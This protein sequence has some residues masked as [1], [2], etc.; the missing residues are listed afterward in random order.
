MAPIKTVR[1]IFAELRKVCQH[2][3]LS[4]PELESFELSEEEQHRQL[5]NTSGK[6][7]F[8]KLLL[9]KLK[10]RGH[11]V[12]LFSQFKI[13][14]DRVEDFLYGEGVN[15][16]R[17]DGDVQQ[18][19]RQKSMDLFNAPNSEYDVFLLTTRA[20]GVG[21]NLATAD[22]VIIYDPD[23]N[24]HQDLQAISRSHRYGQKKRVLVFKLMTKG[25]IEERIMNRG[26]K[27][28]VLDH[29]V[30]QQMG[31]ENEEGDVDDLLLRGAEAVYGDQGGVNALDI[32]YTSK[33]VDELIDKVEADAEAEAKA[34]EEREQAMERGAFEAGP[35]RPTMQ[36]GFAKIWEADQNQLRDAA[37]DDEEEVEN[38]ETNW[39]QIFD[40]M[41]KERQARL[42]REVDDRRTRR[43]RSIQGQYAVDSMD[44]SPASKKK[45]KMI[46]G[47]F[48]ATDGDSSSDADFAINPEDSSDDDDVASI[49]SFPEGLSGL[50]TDDN[51]NVLPR[52]IVT[53]HKLTQKIKRSLKNTQAKT[54]EQSTGTI[55]TVPGPSKHPLTGLAPSKSR[56]RSNETEEQRAARKAAKKQGGTAVPAVAALLEALHGS[57]ANNGVV[58]SLHIPPPLDRQLIDAQNIIS[59][60]FQILSEFND[61][62][63]LKTWAKIG[64]LE[65]SND[66]RLDNYVQ[67]ARLIDDRLAAHGQEQYFSRLQQ[68][69]KVL[70]LIRSR[71]SVIPD[72]PIMP[73]LPDNVGITRPSD[74]GTDNITNGSSSGHGYPP[75]PSLMSAQGHTALVA[76]GSPSADVPTPHLSSSVSSAV[77]APRQPVTTQLLAKTDLGMMP[78]QLANTHSLSQN[79]HKSNSTS[80]NF[81]NSLMDN[82]DDACEFCH[83]NHALP[84]CDRLMSMEDIEQCERAIQ[85]NNEPERQRRDALKALDRQR[86]WN[87]QAGR[88]ASSRQQLIAGPPT[89]GRHTPQ[90]TTPLQ[91]KSVNSSQLHTPLAVNGNGNSHHHGLASGSQGAAIVI[92]DDEDLAPPKGVESHLNGHGSS[93]VASAN[94]SRKTKSLLG[95]AICES[96]ASHSAVQC[97]VVKA[98]PPS[99][100]RALARLGSDHPLYPVVYALWEKQSRT[101]L[102]PSTTQAQAQPQLSDKICPF[103]E[104]QCGRDIKSCVEAHG[105]RKL[106]KAKIR[107]LQL[108]IEKASQVERVITLHDMSAELYQVYQTWPKV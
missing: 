105:G 87:V 13:A 93:P 51:G 41:Q 77:T 70:E 95:C 26:K 12:L 89:D 9:P 83:A 63:H 104:I 3:Y 46:K 32:T 59:W 45:R 37:P 21:I 44:D 74:N 65:L 62:S 52:N 55:S 33:N 97:P 6:L 99:M 31:K 67:L 103:C 100:A 28:I 7:M 82:I 49:S 42:T 40:N 34:L 102:H 64:L 17:L 90:K 36:F 72:K 24:P 39:Q 1:N 30:V 98:G 50:A 85:Q 76:H 94:N 81:F 35:S 53:K 2:P 8:L 48:K 22:T 91:S 60:M 4:A 88:T 54:S 57:P 20:G 71:A 16:L 56:K 25:T 84:D 43:M 68:K 66:E 10:E 92:E 15:F 27:K 107:Q 18:A 14:L 23:W 61:S 78:T 47:K 86:W 38:V 108:D 96:P 79:S 29:L 19:Q 5:I 58:H 11:R 69:N 106:L 75:G 73:P 101:N 80:R